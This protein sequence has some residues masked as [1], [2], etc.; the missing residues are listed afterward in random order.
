MYSSLLLAV[1]CDVNFNVV[2]IFSAPVGHTT[3]K[4]IHVNDVDSD[5]ASLAV[6]VVAGDSEG[7]FR[8]NI[9]TYQ[10]N[11]SRLRIGLQVTKIFEYH[12]FSVLWKKLIGKIL[13]C[14]NEFRLHHALR[15]LAYSNKILICL[16]FFIFF[17]N[18]QQEFCD[19]FCFFLAYEAS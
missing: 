1:Q 2:F 19:N 8:L 9:R 7:L 16:N 4:F 15:V 11:G 3:S 14:Q 12:A 5:A 10:N 17:W 18:I 13:D 6:Y